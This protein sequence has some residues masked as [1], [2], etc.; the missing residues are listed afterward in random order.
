M[1][2]GKRAVI[3]AGGGGFG[4]V[5]TP[6]IHCNLITLDSSTATPGYSQ[7]EDTSEQ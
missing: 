4:Q 5:T 1:L 3:T 7:Q 6:F 2:R